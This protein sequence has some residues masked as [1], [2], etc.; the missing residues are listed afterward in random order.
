MIRFFKSPQPAVLFA[1]P[2]IVLVLWAQ[3]FFPHPFIAESGSV[4][5]LDFFNGILTK[6]PD[7]LQVILVIGFIS[8]EAI[9]LN[10]IFNRHEVLDKN[11][12][13]PAFMYILMMSLC[14]S[15]LR[16]HPVILVNLL[17]LG[18]LDKTFA[19]FKQESPV[20]LLF[21]SCFL[22]SIA[23]LVYFPAVTMFILFLLALAILRH[24]SIREWLIAIIGF[25]LPY[26]FLSVYF[27]WTDQLTDGLKKLISLC[28]LKHSQIAFPIHRPMLVLSVSLG[29]LLLLSLNRLR[30]NFYKNVVRTRSY[31]Q[32]LLFFFVIA[33]ASSFLINTI[34]VYQFTLMAIPLTAFFSHY[35]LSAKRRPA[36][37]EIIL[38][39]LI[40]IIF[41][42]HL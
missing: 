15:L 40:G 38:W 2:F 1:V 39:M 33:A 13:L 25:S 6:I 28:A 27:L 12:Y 8:L 42:N 17:L 11:S 3:A 21:D 35:F 7:F 5:L 14:A 29:I 23:S 16:F 9:Y 36:L 41:W 22:I 30:Q 10:N 32:I 31:Q 4:P 26:F 24:F 37:M 18:A 19:L 34:P 20:S